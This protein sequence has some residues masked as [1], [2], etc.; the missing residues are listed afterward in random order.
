MQR[1]FSPLVKLLAVHR[2]V[3]KPTLL[4]LVQI[5]DWILDGDHSSQTTFQQVTMSPDGTHFWC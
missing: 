3:F 5:N 2:D 4:T 1:H